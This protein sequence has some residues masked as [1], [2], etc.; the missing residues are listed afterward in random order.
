MEK[1]KQAFELY[2]RSNFFFPIRESL[3]ECKEERGE[4]GRGGGAG[5]I[6]RGREG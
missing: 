4:S 5:V 3:T 1:L 2:P 6:E